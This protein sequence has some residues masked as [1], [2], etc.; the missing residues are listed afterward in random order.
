LLSMPVKSVLGL[1]GRPQSSSGALHMLDLLRGLHEAG[2]RV[3]LLCRSIPPEASDRP[4]DFPVIAWREAGLKSDPL[5]YP[6]IRAAFPKGGIGLVHVCGTQL[7]MGGRRIL[8]RVDAPAVFMAGFCPEDVGE[9]A[10]IQRRCRRIIALNQSMR[11]TLVNRVK[12]PRDKVSVVPP[13]LDLRPYAMAHEMNGDG[14]DSRDHVPV[15]AMS[16]PLE[17]GQGHGL[18]LEAAR[19]VLDAGLRVEWLVGGDGPLERKLRAHADRLDLNKRLTFATGLSGRE[20]VVRTADIFVRPA[21]VGGIGTQLIEAMSMGKPVIACATAGIVEIVDDG[22]T[23]AL[24][25]KNSPEALADAIGG[26]LTLSETAKVM[27]E[28]GRQR[29]VEHFGL[30]QFVRNTLKVYEAA[31]AG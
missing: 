28:A 26:I 19:R 11:E 20:A 13:G 25:P 24:V 31:I 12:I 1:M 8:S 30:D 29:A 4:I 5:A 10:R 27:G 22:V 14:P 17:P 23:G 6:E 2:C 9:M 3:A 15:V 21:E 7:G 18:F 16:A